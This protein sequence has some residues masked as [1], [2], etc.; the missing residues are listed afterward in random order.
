MV[1]SL[2]L[3]GPDIERHLLSGEGG[4][5][6]LDKVGPVIDVARWPLASAPKCGRRRARGGRPGNDGV[7]LSRVI[8]RNV[9]VTGFRTR[10][11]SKIGPCAKSFW[12]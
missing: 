9:L 6:E 5:A 7:S 2:G 12:R 8:M 10:Y 11:K 3:I 4:T 1:L